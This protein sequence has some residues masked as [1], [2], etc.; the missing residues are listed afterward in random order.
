MERDIASAALNV[1]CGLSDLRECGC[2]RAF[3]IQRLVAGGA[4]RLW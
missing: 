3:G 4:R 1:K 2:S